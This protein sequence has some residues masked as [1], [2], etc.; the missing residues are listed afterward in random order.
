MGLTISMYLCTELCLDPNGGITV[1]TVS[2]IDGAES[3]ET[4][5]VKG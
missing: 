5:L 1:F 2:E 4:V 3:V